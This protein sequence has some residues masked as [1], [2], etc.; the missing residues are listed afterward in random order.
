MAPTDILVRQHEATLRKWCDPLGI[1]VVLLTGREKGEKRREILHKMADGSAQIIVGTHALFQENVQFCKLGLVLIDEQ[2]RFGVDQRL[3]LTQKGERVDVLVMTATPIPR[4]LALTYYGDMDI[5]KIDEK[6]PTRKPIDTR[7]L[8]VSKM[9]ETIQKL[10]HA[11]AGGAQVYWVCPLIEETEKSDLANATQRFETL[12]KA[13]PGRVALIHGKMKGPQKDALMQDFIDK[14]TD[15]LV[16][17]TVIE[18]GVDVPSASIMIIEQAERFGLSQLHQLRG[19]IGRGS[20][21]SVCLLLYQAP[22]SPTAKKRLD[23]M[24]KTEDGFLIAEEDLKLRGAGEVL[25]TRQSGLQSFK[26]AD[27]EF[28]A[29]L[30]AIARDDAKLILNQDASL[31]SPRGMALK[32]LLYLF[33]KDNEVKTIHSG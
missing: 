3:A 25:G 21:Q 27:L 22:L 14:K 5:S 18:V 1:S 10:Y 12:E 15:I 29:P 19:R 24:R 32:N 9:E 7:V 8:P 20:A 17:T 6:P 13:F 28:H 26:L 2:H 30:L 31:S 16:A 33:N 4:T 11:L 23:V